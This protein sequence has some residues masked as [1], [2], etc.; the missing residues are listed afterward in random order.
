MSVSLTIYKL[1]EGRDQVCFAPCCVFA[2]HFRVPFPFIPPLS[3]QL[4]T[5]VELMKNTTDTTT[6]EEIENSDSVRRKCRSVG[7]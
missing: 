5:N 6:L 3:K 1:L 7:N 4:I 2:E